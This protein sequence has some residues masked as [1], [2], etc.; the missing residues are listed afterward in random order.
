MYTDATEELKMGYLSHLHSRQ[1]EM[2]EPCTRAEYGL[3]LSECLDYGGAG[4]EKAYFG[5]FRCSFF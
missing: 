3:I 5:R 2:A 4:R 1:E